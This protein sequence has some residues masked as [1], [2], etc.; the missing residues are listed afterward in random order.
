MIE[1]IDIDSA[2]DFTLIWISGIHYG[3][4]ERTE[5]AQRSSFKPEM[6]PVNASGG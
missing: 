6:H 5:E 4:T 3:S 1:S 2:H